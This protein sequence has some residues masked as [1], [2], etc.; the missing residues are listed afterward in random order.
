MTLAAVASGATMVF[1]TRR[2]FQ[3]GLKVVC[4]V[5][6]YGIALRLHFS[7]FF[8]LVDLLVVIAGP[9]E[10]R[11]SDLRAAIYRTK[12]VRYPVI[13]QDRNQ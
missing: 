5:T 2:V 11:G 13:T 12:P 8:A 3:S 9:P 1:Q 10:R 7:F 6:M 4:R